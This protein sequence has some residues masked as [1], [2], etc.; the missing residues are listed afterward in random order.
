MKS[1]V[2][3]LT[4]LLV[5]LCGSSASLAAEAKTPDYSTHIA[6]IFRK[7]CI[8][9]HNATETEGGLVLESYDALLKGGKRGAAIVPKSADRSRLVGMLTGKAEPAMPPEGNEPPKPE[10]IALVKAWIDAGAA[11]PSGAAAD[12]TLLVSPRV[13]LKVKPRAS[14]SAA[15]WSPDGKIIALAGY[16]AVRLISPETRETLRE[17]PAQ[18]GN[19][20]AVSF[21]KDGQLLLGAAG[22]PGLFGEVRLFSIADGKLAGTFTGHRDSLYAAALSPDGKTLATSSYDEKVSLWDTSPSPRPSP[23][24]GEGGGRPNPSSRSSL[25]PQP[26]PQGGEASV[27]PRLTL[28]GHNGAVFDLAFSPDSRLLATASGDRTV[29]LWETATGR[30]LDTFGEPLKEVYT[31]AFSPDG[32][33]VAGAGVDN[34]IRV[35]RLSES[36]REGTNQLV[37]SRFA[38]Q[39]AIIKLV[40]SS[41]GRALAS[42]A[43]DRTVKL[44]DATQVAAG[45]LMERHVLPPQSDW[46]PA[47]AFSPD[48]KRL[49]VGRMDGTH[50]IYEVA[51]AK[52]VPPP[53]PELSGAPRPRGIQQGT[54][55][56]VKLAGKNLRQLTAVQTNHPQLTGRITETSEKA[57]SVTLEVTAAQSVPR[58]VYELA[59]TGEGGTSGPVKLYVDD[60]PQKEEAEPNELPASAGAASLPSG[61]WGVIAR[62]GD[63]DYYAFDAK[64]RQTIVCELSATNLGSKLNGV[65]TIFD[66]AGRELADSNDFDDGA[67]P[68]VAFSVPRDGR[69]VVRVNDL[70]L[71]A[72]AD[73]FY[74]LSIGPFAYVTGCFPLSVPTNTETEV[75]LAGFNLPQGATARIKAAGSG[76]M[77]L[78][79]DTKRYR[80]RQGISLLV[81]SAADTIEQEPNDL[82]A[83]ATPL[84]APGAASGRIWG[85]GASAPASRDDVDHY[86]FRAKAGET[87]I[88]ETQAARRGSPIDT[89]IDVLDSAGQ[90]VPRMLLQ[91]VRDSYITFRP[92]DS[93]AAEARV[94][95]W[96]EMEL[97]EYLYLNGEVVKLF[98]MPQGPDSAFVF[99]TSG[100]ARRCFFDTNPTAH[101]LDEPCYI[102]QPHPVGAKLVPTGLPV[103]TL[104]YGNDDDGERKLGRDSK[105]Y[106]TAPADG[107]YVVRVSDVR[108][109][110]GDRF[111]YRLI[112]RRPQ[113]DFSVSIGG[114]NPT[115]SAG[116][117][118]EITFTADR[119]D[120][121]DGEIQIEVTGLPPGFSISSPIAIQAGHSSATAVIHAAADAPQPTAENAVKTQVTAKANIGQQP[122]AKPLGSL[123]RISLAAKP[124]VVV[125]LDPPE[126]VIRPGTTVTAT[127]RIERNG[128]NDRIQFNVNNLPHG[129]IVDNIGLNGVLIPEG[130]TQRQLFINARSWVPETTRPF[131]AVA[132]VA[133]VQVSPP[134]VLRVVK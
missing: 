29:K 87:W 24:G 46:A 93:R 104:Y 86:R 107:D 98:R 48:G 17:L 130:Q 27:K 13:A 52:V 105:V 30:R 80:F 85:A 20:N 65:L 120:G 25:S 64:A 58:G 78:V 41:D 134:I 90:P 43:E 123:G 118:K 84:T 117:G 1:V 103:F 89:R 34:R 15:A 95:N 88:I 53:K 59:V 26:S 131:H 57:D 16:G 116:S 79:L 77:P 83:N 92:V 102:V 66:A 112:V 76:E 96:E 8:G 106:F 7:Y 75:S 125:R 18:R 55:T 114:M 133:G 37:V 128:F 129:V 32:R 72:S 111:A 38:H 119:A 3:A 91:A 126:L 28:E 10:E 68:L 70:A 113:P 23:Q 2:F 31:V 49:A 22:E 99:Y 9:C 4:S 12:P 14:I 50:T 81:S 11:G 39:G 36:A 5:F 94:A 132:P 121:F 73:H 19:V 6:P 54:P 124:Q 62:P 74:R 45:I 122:V 69:Y 47:L 56:K 51:T 67:D 71:G 33:A 21:S 109:H 40:W 97:N 35:W 42:S 82:V 110:G 101:A 44:W 115:V 127:L 100:G 108:G 60:T 63:A 61:F